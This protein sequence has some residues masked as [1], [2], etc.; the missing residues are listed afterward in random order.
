MKKSWWASLPARGLGPE[1]QP[2]S[3]CRA[4]P[5]R[6]IQSGPKTGWAKTGW[7]DPF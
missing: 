7:A 2:V 4:S 1:M 5:A 3:P 6:P